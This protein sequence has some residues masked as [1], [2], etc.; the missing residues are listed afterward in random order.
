MQLE[1][2]IED[3]VDNES[4]PDEIAY[5]EFTLESKVPVDDKLEFK[6]LSFDEGYQNA[7]DVDLLNNQ[8]EVQEQEGEIL[9]QDDPFFGQDFMDFE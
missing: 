8:L 6:E 4:N 5:E 2:D 3:H 9:N 1:L 7:I